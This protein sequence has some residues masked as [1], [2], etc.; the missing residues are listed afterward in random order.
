[1]LLLLPVGVGLNCLGLK[2][3][4]Q[5]EDTGRA[6]FLYENIIVSGSATCKCLTHLPH[7]IWI[8]HE[9]MRITETAGSPYSG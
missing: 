2:R 7:V 9:R 6:F 1:M 5:S 3:P 4:D 8:I